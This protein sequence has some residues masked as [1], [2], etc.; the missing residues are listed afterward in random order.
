MPII[1][2]K[3]EFVYPKYEPDFD[4]E[5]GPFVLGHSFP[6][7]CFMTSQQKEMLVLSPNGM[8]T[9]GLDKWL[10]RWTVAGGEQHE[11]EIDLTGTDEEQQMQLDVLLVVLKMS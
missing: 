2:P 6:N 11:H 1:D 7:I 3:V 4:I 5:L 9:K 8:S 10:I